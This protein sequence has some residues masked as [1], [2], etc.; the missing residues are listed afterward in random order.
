[1]VV[2]QYRPWSSSLWS[3]LHFPVTSSVLGLNY[4]K[5]MACLI[6]IKKL[7][8]CMCYDTVA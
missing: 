1:M 4:F 7:K 8:R 3:F 6:N 2:E 5:N